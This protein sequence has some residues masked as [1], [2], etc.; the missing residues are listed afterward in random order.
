[1]FVSDFITGLLNSI[2]THV[3]PIILI[4]RIQTGMEIPGLRDSLVK[5]L[6]DYNLQVY[7]HYLSRVMTK[8]VDSICE[9]QRRRLISI[10][11]ICLLDSIIPIDA[12]SIISRLL[13]ASATEQA[14]LCLTWS[15]TSEDR[16]SRDEAQF[17]KKK[18]AQMVDD[19]IPNTGHWRGHRY[20]SWV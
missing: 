12:I 8:P 16:F 9:Q 11:I 17:K 1:M 3:D 18:R 4:H 5:I 6:Q 20:L 14:S 2:G 19:L 15:H 7:K 10:F 13:L